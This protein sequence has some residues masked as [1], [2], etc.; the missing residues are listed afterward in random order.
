M[1]TSTAHW[2]SQHILSPAMICA[3]TVVCG[4]KRQTGQIFSNCIFDNTIQFSS[5]L[6]W[7]RTKTSLNIAYCSHFVPHKVQVIIEKQDWTESIISLMLIAKVLTVSKA[8]RGLQITTLLVFE[9][10]SFER[11]EVYYVGCQGLWHKN[12]TVWLV[13]YYFLFPATLD[14]LR[15]SSEVFSNKFI[16]VWLLTKILACS[17]CCNTWHPT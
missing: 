14:R 2:V 1:S 3:A 17:V 12:A 9:K 7:D 10:T 15:M 13:N 11:W 6:L 4:G 8:A 16:A 5:T